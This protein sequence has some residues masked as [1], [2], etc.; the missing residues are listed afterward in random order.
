M[1]SESFL[2]LDRTVIPWGT[3]QMISDVNR[4]LFR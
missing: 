3:R 4:S 1:V 2:P